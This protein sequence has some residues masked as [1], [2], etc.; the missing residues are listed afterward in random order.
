MTARVTE[1]LGTIDERR[2]RELRRDYVDVAWFDARKSRQRVV[3]E[4]RIELE[5]CLP[6]G[7]FISDGAVL[8][9]GQDS[10]LVARREPARACRI[11]FSASA[12]PL[13]ALREAAILGHAL[14]NQHVP[15]EFDGEELL[16]PVLT[17]DAV[18]TETIERLGL[19]TVEV[20]FGE[21][22]LFAHEPA[23]KFAAANG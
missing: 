20:H 7:A 9:A 15:I 18:M 11:S 12:D 10:V 8:W 2:F 21:E 4:G 23:T 6:A 16:A 3:S 1:L 22:R 19:A 13:T 17:S 5:L 14:G